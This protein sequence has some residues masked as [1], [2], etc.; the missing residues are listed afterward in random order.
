M[1]TIRLFSLSIATALLVAGQSSLLSWAVLSVAQWV[2]R[3][4]QLVER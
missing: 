3:V 2:A 1:K 4:A